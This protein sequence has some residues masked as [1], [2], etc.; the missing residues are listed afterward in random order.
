M[1]SGIWFDNGLLCE[2]AL[3]Y[4]TL[5]SANILY[6]TGRIYE[7]LT[8][9]YG[10]HSGIISA[11][12]EGNEPVKDLAQADALIR[13][14]KQLAATSESVCARMS[15]PVFKR[16][17]RTFVKETKDLLGTISQSFPQAR[18]DRVLVKLGDSK[19]AP[20]T[21]TNFFNGPGKNGGSQNPRRQIRH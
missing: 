16:D 9:L 18:L 4:D 7:K 10:L 2:N 5:P 20:G 19:A 11:L 17:T 12:R 14:I 8:V 15:N 21:E 13:E 1:K 6:L 3:H